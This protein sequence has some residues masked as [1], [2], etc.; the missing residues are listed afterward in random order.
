MSGGPTTNRPLTKTFCE[1]CRKAF[2]PRDPMQ[3]YQDRYYHPQCF[4]CSQCGNT[5]AGKPFYPKPNNQFQCENC[6]HSLAPV[7]VMKLKTYLKK[8]FYS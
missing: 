3:M 4:C 6:N 8:F 1:A 5:L 2:T 7:Y